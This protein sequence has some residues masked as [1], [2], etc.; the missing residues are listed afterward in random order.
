MNQLI[1]PFKQIIN[2]IDVYR[3]KTNAVSEFIIE[4]RF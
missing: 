1:T 3:M 4:G 2:I